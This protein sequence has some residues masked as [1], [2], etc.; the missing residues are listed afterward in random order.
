MHMHYKGLKSIK[1]FGKLATTVYGHG[2][3]VIFC[4]YKCFSPI[5]KV[6]C[7]AIIL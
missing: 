1:K 7:V 4:M 2:E 5:Q 3:L 6:Q